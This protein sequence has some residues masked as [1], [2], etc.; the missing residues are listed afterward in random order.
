MSEKILCRVITGPTASGKSGH[1]LR[2][3][4]EKGYEILCMDSMQ[5]YRGMD[6]GTAKPTPEEQ[7]TVPH[8]LLD[9]ADPTENFNVASWHDLAEAKIRQLAEEGKQVL[10]VGGTGLYLESLVHP[11]ALGSVPADEKIREELRR[12]GETYGGRTELHEMLRALDPVTAERLPLNDL[13]RVIRAIEVSRITGIPFSAQP[14]TGQES[15]F[16]WR[17][18][19]LIPERQELY[20][21][22]DERVDRM[23]ADGLAEEVRRLLD[24]GVP[25][26]AR[27]MCGLGYKE[28]IPYLRGMTDLE[29]AAAEIRL[30]TRHYA[31]RQMTYMKRFENAVSVDPLADGAYERIREILCGEE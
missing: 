7:R 4:R 8:H 28:M 15:E 16:D 14:R 22:I 23:I 9:V 26:D 13:Q 10:L 20:R 17:I 11:M 12:L 25:E 1:A 19:V 31:K 2:L 21:R 18:A 5:I 6:I 24:G 30:G 3:A 27:S 29:T